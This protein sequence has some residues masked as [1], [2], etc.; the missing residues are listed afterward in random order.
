M[1]TIPISNKIGVPIYRSSSGF[2]FLIGTNFAHNGTYNSDDVKI[3]KEFNRDYNLLHQESR[4]RAMERIISNP[5]NFFLLMEK[6]YVIQWGN[7]DFGFYWSTAKVDH[8]N[9]IGEFLINRPRKINTMTQL[10]YLLI[11]LF[12][13][14]GCIKYKSKH[15]Y[16]IMLFVMLFFGVFA[17]QTFLEVQT[18]YHFSAIPTFIMMAGYGLCHFSSINTKIVEN[19]RNF[20]A[21]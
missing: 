14:I 21:E 17:T 11:L 7:E 6:K 12:S 18:R 20:A 13:I 19:A 3:I 16:P 9:K 4:K 10:Y 5:R 15:I 2:S 1:L 8:T